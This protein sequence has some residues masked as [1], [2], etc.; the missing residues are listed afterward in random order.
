ML[1]TLA[2]LFS[3]AAQRP[4]PCMSRRAVLATTLISPAAAARAFDL[5]PYTTLAAVVSPYDMRPSEEAAAEYAAMPN[6]D[7]S[8][9]QSC[10]VYAI[11]NDDLPSLQAMAD[12]GWSLAELADDNSVT[13]LHV[14]A[15]AGNEAAVRLLLKA[16]S[17]TS[18]D[19]YTSFKET[20]LHLAVRNNRL[21]CV[22]ALV[23]AGASTS[24]PYGTKGQD[25]ALTLAKKYNFDR[26]VEY[27]QKA[28]IAQVQ[29]VM[30][31]TPQQLAALSPEQ[32]AQ[33][34]ALRAKLAGGSGR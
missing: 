3:L 1:S 30:S 26:I 4:A 15:K 23:E 24:A 11:T 31:L 32:R 12:G 21:A 17:Q 29:Q 34:E 27:L 14:A 7:R 8:K 5:P 28:K 19:A 10:A 16:S 18:I 13:L 2:V 25:T 33:V 20:P 22:K 9:Q 6:P